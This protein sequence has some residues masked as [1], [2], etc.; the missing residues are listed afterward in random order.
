MALSRSL[1]ALLCVELSHEGN[2]SSI[3][4]HG[5]VDL[6]EKSEARTRMTGA[7]LSP[8]PMFIQLL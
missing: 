4:T 6:Q 7:F 5:P 1:T 3:E 8:L 2:T